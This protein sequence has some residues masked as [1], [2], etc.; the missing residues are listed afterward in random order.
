M[1]LL[2][3]ISRIYSILGRFFMVNAYVEKYMTCIYLRIMNVQQLSSFTF[4]KNISTFNYLSPRYVNI[5]S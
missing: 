4:A 5:F 1:Q 2:F 3:E